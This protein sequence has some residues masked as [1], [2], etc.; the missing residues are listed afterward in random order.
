MNYGDVLEYMLPLY[1]RVIDRSSRGQPFCTEVNIIGKVVYEPYN[2][3]EIKK[4]RKLFG[5]Q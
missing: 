2:V 3:P 1:Q 4:F 5:L